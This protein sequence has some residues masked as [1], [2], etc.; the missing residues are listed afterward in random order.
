MRL[1]IRITDVPGQIHWAVQSRMAASI[2]RCAR[3]PVVVIHAGALVDA[4]TSES[5]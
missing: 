1:F 2:T 4:K 3:Q 5:G